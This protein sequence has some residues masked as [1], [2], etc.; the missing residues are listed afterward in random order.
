MDQIASHSLVRRLRQVPIFSKLDDRSLIRVLGASASLA[1]SEDGVVFRAG[2][3]G[4]ALY[5][6]ISGGVDVMD[7]QRL[8]VQIGED[9]WF[10][11]LALLYPG[12]QHSKTAIARGDTELLVLRSTWFEALLESDPDLAVHFRRAF[13]ERERAAMGRERGA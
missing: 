11:E 3:P 1:W 10:G 2:E 12:S 8:V 4:E 7:G 9:G 13:E 5:I 6:V